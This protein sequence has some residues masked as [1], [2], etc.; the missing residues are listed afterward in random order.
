MIEHINTL[1]T[2]FSKFSAME[3]N[4]EEKECVELLLQSLLDSY[5]HLII[6]VVN[7]AWETMLIF[8]DVVATTFEE[9]I[10][11]KNKENKISPSQ[12][13]NALII[14]RGRSRE[15]GS[16][17]SHKQNKPKSQDKTKVKYNH[18]EKQG[19]VE[20]ECWH[21]NESERET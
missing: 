2:L 4:I 17:E 9:E 3:H 15:H 16:S 1:K 20:K 18:Y 7:G 10:R 14:A 19:H 11:R 6:N 21:Y 8:N 13:T 12:Q 5:D